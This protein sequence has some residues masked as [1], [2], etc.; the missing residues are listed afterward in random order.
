MLLCPNVPNV[1]WLKKKLCWKPLSHW[2][3]THRSKEASHDIIS[4][5]VQGNIQPTVA[6]WVKANHFNPGLN[7]HYP[8][9][10]VKLNLFFKHC[11]VLSF[12]I[13]NCI[14]LV[15]TQLSTPGGYIKHT[16]SFVEAWVNRNAINLFFLLLLP[17]VVLSLKCWI[18]KAGMKVVDIKTCLSDLQPADDGF[19]PIPRFQCSLCSTSF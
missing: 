15:T 19:A 10:S 13:F 5:C 18:P 3:G 1:M 17:A 6:L 16:P 11:S 9:H 4:E 12:F 2:G 7:I 8:I 14:V